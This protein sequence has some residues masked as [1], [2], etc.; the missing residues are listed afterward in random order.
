MNR[1]PALMRPVYSGND[2]EVAELRRALSRSLQFLQTL[3]FAEGVAFERLDFGPPPYADMKDYPL[4]HNLGRKARGITTLGCTPK[5]SPGYIPGIPLHA[6]GAD[7][8]AIAYVRLSASMAADYLW[9][10]WVW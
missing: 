6:S 1:R 9:S 5:N 8:D 4:R 3:P 2:P 10:F 7:T